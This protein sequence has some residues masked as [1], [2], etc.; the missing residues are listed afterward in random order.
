VLESKFTSNLRHKWY[1]SDGHNEAICLP[2]SGTKMQVRSALYAHLFWESC[3]L[4][5]QRV[6]WMHICGQVDWP[7]S[8]TICGLVWDSSQWSVRTGYRL[9]VPKE[10]PTPSN[11]QSSYSAISS[12]S[13]LQGTNYCIILQIK[14]SV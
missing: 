5:C 12:A 3:C 11:M 9:C 6:Y 4:L 1:S 13:V 7:P 8:V 2:S 14:L 10:R